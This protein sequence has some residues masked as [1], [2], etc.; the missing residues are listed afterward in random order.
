M[1]S[2]PRTGPLQKLTGKEGAAIEGR[3]GVR[4]RGRFTARNSRGKVKSGVWWSTIRGPEGGPGMREMLSPTRPPSWARGG[5]GS[6]GDQRGRF[7]GGRHGRVGHLSTERR[8]AGTLALVKKRRPI[9]IDAERR[10]ITCTSAGR[11][12]SSAGANLWVRRKPYARRVL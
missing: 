5:P 7:S 1:G 9:T 10:E 12:S 11:P 8:S 2:R 6:R 4:F 3:R